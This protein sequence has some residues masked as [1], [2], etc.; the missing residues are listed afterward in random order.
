MLEVKEIFPTLQGEGGLIGQPSIFVRFAKCNLAC[1]FCD[2]DFAVGDMYEV[3]A[4]VQKLLPMV[5]SFSPHFVFTGGE[6]LLQPKDELLALLAALPKHCTFTFETNF[7]PPT[8]EVLLMLNGEL[9]DRVTVSASPKVW[10]DRGIEDCLTIMEML[11]VGGI[12][13]WIKLVVSRQNCAFM[14]KFIQRIRDL[15]RYDR[16][17]LFIQPM[18]PDLDVKGL[19]EI[20]PTKDFPDVRILPQMHKLVQLP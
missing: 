12:S 13:F 10:N 4:L 6:P 3:D 14:Q 20:W 11:A 9:A 17:M 15:V 8:W 16:S 18:W 7:T 1:R 19:F 2:T 5:E